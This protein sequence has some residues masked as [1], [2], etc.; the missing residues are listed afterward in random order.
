MKKAFIICMTCC[1]MSCATTK[2]TRSEPISLADGLKEVVIALDEMSDVKRDKI[3]GL[4][5]SDVTV[6]FN[7]TSGN[8]KKNDASLEIV[9][10]GL[11]SKIG[12]SWSSEVTETTGNKITI[13]F[14]SILFAN[15][16]DLIGGNKSVEDIT[17]MVKDL[18][19]GG[20]NTSLLPE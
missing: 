19:D 3:N 14:R 16:D 12:A 15:K 18:E 4:V 10:T 11:V 17:K 6:E 13:K 2:V 8:K 9:P 1:M 7:V 20:W 5:P